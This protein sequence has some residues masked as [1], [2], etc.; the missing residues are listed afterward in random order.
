MTAR[1]TDGLPNR[2]RSAPDAD[3]AEIITRIP[4][5]DTMIVL[6]NFACDDMGRLWWQV[7]YNGTLGWTVENNGAEYWLEPAR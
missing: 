4:A 5:G 2:L 7:E 1:V 6:A 3:G